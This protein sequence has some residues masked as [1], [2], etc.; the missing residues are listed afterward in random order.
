MTDMTREEVDAK[1]A[2]SEARTD[3]KFAKLD[4]KLDLILLELGHGKEERA[5]LRSD[6]ASLRAEFSSLRAD[7]QATRWTI[8]GTGV[9]SVIAV[10]GSMAVLVQIMQAN[11]ANLIAVFQ[12]ALAAK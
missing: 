4:G 10:I 5:T 12:A 9:A 7:N 6:F 11:Q 1:I 8:I 3:T 2:A